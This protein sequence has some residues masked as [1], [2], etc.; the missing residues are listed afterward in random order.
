MKQL[1]L[2]S[3]F[4]MLWAF[5]CDKDYNFET[6]TPKSLEDKSYKFQ[7]YSS[8]GDRGSVIQRM[9]EEAI[10]NNADL[11]NFDSKI[12]AIDE[13]KSDSM[14]AYHAYL[15]KVDNYW[16]TVDQYINQLNDTVL[17]KAVNKYFA[18]NELEYNA[19]IAPLKNQEA[20][21]NGLHRILEDQHVLM[22]LMVTAPMMKRYMNNEFPN[23][24][25]FKRIQ[26]EFETL[27]EQSKP[28]ALIP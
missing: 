23:I 18:K 20:T 11:K 4:L 2:L 12:N 13:M 28:Y 27:I 17:A 22:K 14:R 26:S 21:I 19:K 10:A 25:T 3:I 8:K 5:G 9:Y 15:S 24:Q 1:T 7:G 6:D 16:S